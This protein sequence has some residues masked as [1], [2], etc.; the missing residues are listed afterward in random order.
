M[1]EVYSGI[2]VLAFIVGI[3]FIQFARDSADLA[4]KNKNLTKEYFI[5]L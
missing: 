4:E 2:A 3:G 1:V 5:K